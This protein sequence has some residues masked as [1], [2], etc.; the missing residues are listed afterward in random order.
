MSVP[1]L[2]LS[3]GASVG[4]GIASVPMIGGALSKPLTDEIVPTR[5][6]DLASYL[7][8]S[9]SKGLGF[10]D[11]ENE[12]S[13]GTPDTAPITTA[14]KPTVPKPPAATGATNEKKRMLAVASFGGGVVVAA[15]AFVLLRRML[16]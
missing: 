11:F 2:I 16:K 5:I 3:L 7:T 1:I 10:E 15:L 13:V 4:A 6:T 14:P 8:L 12:I 9:G